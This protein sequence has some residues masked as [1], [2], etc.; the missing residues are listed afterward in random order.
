[1]GVVPAG[2]LPF[3]VVPPLAADV[4]SKRALKPGYKPQQTTGGTEWIA[5]NAAASSTACMLKRFACCVSR[6]GSGEEGKRS[7]DV[8]SAEEACHGTGSGRLCAAHSSTSGDADPHKITSYG[9]ILSF[10]SVCVASCSLPL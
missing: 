5:K 8:L 2:S 9:D 3:V 6:M 4:V 7:Q 1:V 10:S